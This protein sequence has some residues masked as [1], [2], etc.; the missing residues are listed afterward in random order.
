M[1]RPKSVR[2]GRGALL[3]RDPEASHVAVQG[4]GVDAELLRGA[5][6]PTGRAEPNVLVGINGPEP[7]PPPA[8]ASHDIGGPQGPGRAPSA[9]GPMKRH[10]AFRRGAVR[11]RGVL[12]PCRSG[13]GGRNVPGGT[14]VVVST[15]RQMPR[16]P[17]GR[18]VRE[19][20]TVE[21]IKTRR[22]IAG[23]L[24][25]GC[26]LMLRFAST[27][28]AAARVTA[29]AGEPRC[30]RMAD[31]SH[32]GLRRPTSYLEMPM[33]AATSSCATV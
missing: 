10:K 13:F 31:M 24:V 1:S 9:A 30:Q 4:A 6:V 21:L 25:G 5:D 22:S 17:L 3:L 15:L 8:R 16:S 11:K 32:S 26:G 20:A 19:G 7:A 18:W 29:R 27:S 33:E 28:E 12:W 23:V 14:G 2:P